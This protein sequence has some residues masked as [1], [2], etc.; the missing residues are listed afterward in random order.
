MERLIIITVIANKEKR[1]ATAAKVPEA[2]L[3][4]NLRDKAVTIGF[5]GRMKDHVQMIDPKIYHCHLTVENEKK[6]LYDRLAKVLPG[7]LRNRLLFWEKGVSTAGIV[8]LRDQSLWLVRGEQSSRFREGRW[9]R[10]DYQVHQRRSGNE[11]STDDHLVACRRLHNNTR[12]LSNDWEADQEAQWAERWHGPGKSTNWGRAR[13]IGDDAG[14]PEHRQIEGEDGTVRVQNDSDTPGGA[15][16]H[17]KDASGKTT[18]RPQ[19]QC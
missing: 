7:I 11:L 9:A 18:I 8:E 10:A 14:F 16:R 19:R 15:P 12:Q 6:V 3:Q 5:E 17:G 13:V 1:K 4:T 2:Y